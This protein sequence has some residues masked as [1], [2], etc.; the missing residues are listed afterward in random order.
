L[1]EA[2][3]LRPASAED[4]PLLQA[5]FAENKAAEL[6]AAGF[7][8]AQIRALVEMQ[9]R[10]RKM[11]YAAQYPAAMDLILLD[12]KG[13]AVGRLLV[14][15]QADCWRIV[16][17]AIR[18][19]YRGLGL[20]T[21]ALQE[22]Q[23]QAAAAGATLALQ[24]MCFNPAFRLYERLGFHAVRENAVMIEMVWSAATEQSE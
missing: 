6:A 23:R 9:S 4:E 7:G 8:E 17:I 3:N 18:T 19:A 12:G 1:T 21:L 2:L 10:G 13:V 16:D 24:V 22:S 11:T 20:G 14:D 5:L 15:R